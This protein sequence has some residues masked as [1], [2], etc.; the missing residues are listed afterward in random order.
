M[1]EEMYQPTITTWLFYFLHLDMDNGFISKI[2]GVGGNILGFTV[3]L[4]F[5]DSSGI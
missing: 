2:R 4:D 1:K 3:L 5:I